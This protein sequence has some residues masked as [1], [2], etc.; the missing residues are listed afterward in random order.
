MQACKFVPLKLKWKAQV[1]SREA[2]K[3][4]LTW[5][6][7][8]STDIVST[9]SL[10]LTIRAHHLWGGKLVQAGD[11]VTRESAPAPDPESSDRFIWNYFQS[12]VLLCYH[13]IKLTLSTSANMD[14]LI[15][16]SPVM[17]VV[18]RPAESLILESTSTVTAKNYPFVKNY[19][20]CCKSLQIYA[21]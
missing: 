10:Q 9:L 5:S 3:S 6:W 2:G 17:Q 13:G 8:G 11:T 4:S 12:S 15:G 19:V 7:S 16:E 14:K 1:S 20:F 21:L 18:L